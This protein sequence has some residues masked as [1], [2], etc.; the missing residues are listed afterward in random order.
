MRTGFRY[1]WFSPRL[2]AILARVFLFI[3]CAGVL[4]PFAALIGRR[5]LNQGDGSVAIMMAC[6]GLG[7]IIGVYYMQALQRSIGIEETVTLC[8]ALYGL[9]MLGV[10]TILS[11]YKPW[12]KTPMGRRG[13]TSSC[14][15]GGGR[16]K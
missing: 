11:V 6:L 15:S 5:A 2:R 9:A 12:G 3:F 10:A 16:S 14:C 4:Q 8:T 1:T 7:A 13:G